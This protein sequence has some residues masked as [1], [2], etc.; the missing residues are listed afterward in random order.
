MSASQNHCKP[1]KNRLLASLP[2]EEQERL[3]PHL[4]LIPLEYKQLLY[5]PNEPIQYVYFPNYG[6]IS[7]ITIMQNGDA[8]EVATI[9]NEGMVGLPILLGANTIPGQALVQVPGEG[10]RIKV[11]V[12][13]REV[14]PGS[15]LYKLLQRYTQALFNSIAQLV[16]CNRLHSIEERFCRWVL[17]TQDRV[18]K[19]EFPLTQEFLGQM[20]GV[21]RASV[22]VVAAMIQK[23]GLI[24]YKRGK[25]TILDREGL[26]D[27]TCECYVMIKDEFESLVDDN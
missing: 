13:Q 24:T 4:E 21:R 14:T 15:P 19:N 17:M 10:L 26:E 7:L 8:V 6:V 20:L 12:F 23:A 2:K 11:D 27:V 1:I 18:G 5:I 9:G 3:Q 22:S 25:M 16:A